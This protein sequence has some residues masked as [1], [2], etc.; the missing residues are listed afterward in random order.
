[1]LALLPSHPHAHSA[2]E[3]TCIAALRDAL[4]GRS[5]PTLTVTEGGRTEPPAVTAIRVALANLNR[6]SETVD[7]SRFLAEF[8]ALPVEERKALLDE[9]RAAKTVIEAWRHAAAAA[10]E[11]HGV[12]M[13]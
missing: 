11:A 6:W 9:I 13:G 8:N 5:A 1:M 4:A 2:E 3:R 12:D 10:C 7:R